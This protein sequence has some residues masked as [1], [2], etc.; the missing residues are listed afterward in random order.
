MPIEK[1]YQFIVYLIPGFI[2]IELYRSIY[3]AKEKKQ[4]DQIVWS[5]I[6]GFIIYG[7]VTAID[8]MLLKDLLKDHTTE[9]PNLY[10]IFSLFICGI[11]IGLFRS[12]L[13]YCC[14]NLSQKFICFKFLKPDPFTIW[15]KINQENNNEWAVVY[16]KD[17]S[18]YIG[19]ISEYTFNPNLVDNDFLLSK[20][21]RIKEDL[22]II[23]T[24]TGIGVYINTRDVI[25]IEYLLGK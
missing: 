10:F 20:A 18:I 16:L 19:Y 14:F 23:Y 3:P 22:S 17:G 25:R 4:F 24:V 2:A 7:I 12:F 13:H 11:I 8:S 15:A 5:V 1:F 21:K 9:F 6:Y